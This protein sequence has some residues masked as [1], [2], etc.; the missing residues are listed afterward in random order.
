MT[1]QEIK[2]AVRWIGLCLCEFPEDEPMYNLNAL[3][4]MLLVTLL[5]F[6]NYYNKHEL[7]LN[8]LS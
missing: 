5:V 8:I 3:D 6:P 7:Y 2:Q 1:D 4:L